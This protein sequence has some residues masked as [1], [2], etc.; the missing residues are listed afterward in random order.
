M[1][2]KALRLVSRTK[3]GENM[4]TQDVIDP[5]FKQ[6]PVILIKDEEKLQIMSNPVYF[7]ILMSLREGYKT[8]KEIEEDYNDYMEKIAIKEA[9][10]KGYTTKKEIDEEIEKKKRSDKSLYRYIKD[11]IETDF[12]AT[13]GKRVALE[14]PMTEKLFARTAKFFFV[15]NFYEKTECQ[16]PKC[17]ESIAKLVELIFNV[18]EV[19]PNEILGFSK[20]LVESTKKVSDILLGPKSENFVEIVE[21]LSLEEVMTVI[22]MLSLIELVL[23]QKEY[24]NILDLVNKK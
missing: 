19:E 15:E 14:K 10:K 7:P 4:E 11:L 6:K 13:I 17:I 20:L 3:C 18:S 5:N 21:E 22:Q 23:N 1:F 8:V 24:K 16:N 2:A 9:K 12:V